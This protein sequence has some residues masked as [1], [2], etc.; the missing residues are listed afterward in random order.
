MYDIFVISPYTHPDPDVV[1]DRAKAAEKYLAFLVKNNM[2]AYS[3]IAA[4]HHLTQEHELPTDY[5]Y[6][7]NHC[8]KMIESA[9]EVHVL[10]LDGWKESDGA[11]DELAIAMNL[12]KI[13]T[14][15]DPL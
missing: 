11:Q 4:M 2:V 14:L 7:K 9:K 15:V 12:G 8:T 6:W 3:T 10:C 13:I 1:C 5:E